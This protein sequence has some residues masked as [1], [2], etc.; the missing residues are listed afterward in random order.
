MSDPGKSLR[1]TRSMEASVQTDL[2]S[3]D[4]ADAIKINPMIVNL[5]NREQ[6]RRRKEE[7]AAY[8]KLP[9]GYRK[10]SA[11]AE[12]PTAPVAKKVLKPAIEEDCYDTGF[13]HR[14]MQDK[15]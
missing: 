9:D 10:P 3:L 2:A 13:K 15:N 4:E 5:S 11:L 14:G 1:Q 7:A 8:S 12:T 6:N